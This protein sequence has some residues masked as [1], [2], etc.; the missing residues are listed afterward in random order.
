YVPPPGLAPPAPAAGRTFVR[1]AKVGALV[2]VG[3]GCVAI[4]AFALPGRYRPG[5]AVALP[6]DPPACP[7][8]D[9]L[10]APDPRPGAEPPQSA[11]APPP[12]PQEEP[13]PRAPPTPAGAPEDPPPHAA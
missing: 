8:L 7:A 1:A 2:I 10:P 3:L 6:L 4:G 5:E 11:G 13:P 9:M 12:P